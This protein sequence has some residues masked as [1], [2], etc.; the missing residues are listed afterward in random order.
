MTGR[1]N[2]LAQAGPIRALSRRE[3]R[4]QHRIGARRNLEARD[5][6]LTEPVEITYERR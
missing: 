4:P 6:A 3:R 1:R 2:Y 5:R